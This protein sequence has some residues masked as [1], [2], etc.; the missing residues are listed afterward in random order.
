M[1]HLPADQLAPV[2]LTVYTGNRMFF[3]PNYP[4]NLDPSFKTDLDFWIVLEGKIHFIVDFNKTDLDILSLSRDRNSRFMVD[5]CAWLIFLYAF[6][7]PS[8]KSTDKH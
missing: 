1:D 2:S 4:K 7:Q 6:L 5:K 8:S 3:L